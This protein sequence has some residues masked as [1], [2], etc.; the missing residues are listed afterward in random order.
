MDPRQPTSAP[1]ATWGYPTPPPLLSAPPMPQSS[2]PVPPPQQQHRIGG[3]SSSSTMNSSS[4]PQP[5]YNRRVEALPEDPSQLVLPPLPP[6]VIPDT[7]YNIP[8]ADVYE[9]I[10]GLRGMVGDPNFDVS[11]LL[12]ALKDSPNLGLA[13]LRV[14]LESGM[15]KRRSEGVMEGPQ[16]GSEVVSVPLPEANPPSIPPGYHSWIVRGQPTPNSTT[17]EN[18]SRRP[19]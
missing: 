18:H 13:M 14:L 17:T 5:Q 15:L 8:I 19:W 16:N 2:Y 1:P 6:P 11:K 9:M 7:M 12:T 4:A 10:R 3:G